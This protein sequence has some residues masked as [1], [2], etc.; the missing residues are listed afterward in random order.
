VL[1]ARTGASVLGRSSPQHG[2]QDRTF[3]P[4]RVLEHGERIELGGVHLRA[5]HTPGHASNHLCYLLE[6]TKMLFTGDHVMQG[7]TVVI[8]PPDGNMLTYLA[9]LELLLAE[10]VRS[11][12]PGTGT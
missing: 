12:R 10:D 7:S 2:N 4:D 6:E 8:N 1:R 9:S 3:V 5:I 11:S